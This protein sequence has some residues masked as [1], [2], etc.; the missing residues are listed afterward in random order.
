MK[1]AK[2]TTKKEFEENLKNTILKS[3]TPEEREEMDKKLPKS[4]RRGNTKR[5]KPS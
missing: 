2:P 3:L 5:N 4:L 1:K